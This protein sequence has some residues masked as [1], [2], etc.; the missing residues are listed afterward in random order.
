[1]SARKPTKA[2]KERYNQYFLN[3]II[4]R[5][6]LLYLYLYFIKF[7]SLIIAIIFFILDNIY[8]VNIFLI[9]HITSSYLIR[10]IDKI[11][12]YNIIKQAEDGELLED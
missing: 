4:L 12:Y 9:I 2:D 10:V 3:N 6:H 7:N 8:G 5:N 1:M 11:I